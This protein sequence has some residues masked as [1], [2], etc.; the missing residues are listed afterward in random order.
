MSGNVITDAESMTATI[1]QSMKDYNAEITEKVATIVDEVG[2]EM[3]EDLKSTSPKKT[4]KYRK[5]WRTEKH[6]NKDGDL[7]IK[8]YNK[9]HPGLTHLL[10]HGHAKKGGG[11]VSGIPHIKIAEEKACKNLLKRIEENL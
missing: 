3:L 11:R 6:Y 4:G 1:L 5:G 2:A 10:E 7:T 8:A 9:T